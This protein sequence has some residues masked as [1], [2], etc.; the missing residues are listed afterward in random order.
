MKLTEKQKKFSRE[1]LKDFNATQA[2]VKAGYSKRSANVIAA[3][4]LTKVSIQQY[5]AKSL[6]KAEERAEIDIS[7]IVKHLHDMAFF[8]VADVLYNDGEIKPI[9]EWPE[10]ARKIVSELHVRRELTEDGQVVTITKIKMPSREKNTENLGRYLAIFTDKIKAE[11]DY[12]E[13]VHLYVPQFR[14]E[15]E[16][17]QIEDEDGGNGK[18]K[19]DDN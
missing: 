9:D 5:L 14:K 7:K 8:D 15:G 4:N 17:I 16:E 12:S 10:I 11:I 1:Y 6:K 2:A 19:T 13:V 3:Q 18:F